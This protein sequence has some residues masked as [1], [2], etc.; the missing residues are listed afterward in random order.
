LIHL[1]A[2]QAVRDVLESADSLKE[3]GVNPVLI[4]SYKRG[5]S[6]RRVKDVDMFCRL[7][8]IDTD[9]PGQDVLDAFYSVL[10]GEFRRDSTGARRV[11]RQA[12]SLQVSFPEFDGLYVDAVPARQRADGYWE[13]PKRDTDEWQQTNPDRLTELKSE[14]N[15]EFNGLY[16][17]GVKLLRQTRRTILSSRPGGLFVELCFYDACHRGVIQ[18]DNQTLVYVSGL[19]AI[20]AYL[21]DK[22]A[23][24]ATLPD[25]TM[26]GQVVQFRATD[27]QWEDAR[28]RFAAAAKKARAAY[29]EEDR[30]VAA[31]AFRALLGRNGNDDWVFPTPAGCNDDGSKRAA[32]ALI[33]AGESSIPAGD[34]RFA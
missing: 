5:V 4:G 6:I 23:W 25:P 14:M 29:A 26:P 8:T 31:A 10:D 1:I 19:E 34:Q 2:H 20:A 12:R 7:D 22:V 21:K 11:K 32:A 28:D 13:I 33:R 9:M 24:G 18:K 3:W 16:V 17:P 15:D 27:L 30:C